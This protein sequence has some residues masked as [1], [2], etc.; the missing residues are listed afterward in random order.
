MRQQPL[1]P[2]VPSTYGYAYRSW[3]RHFATRVA[4][5]KIGLPNGL[6]SVARG[7]RPRPW[8]PAARA[9]SYI[10]HR[11]G[12][13][14]CARTHAMNKPRAEL[15]GL[16]AGTRLLR[17]LFCLLPSRSHGDA[18][19]RLAVKRAD[20][21]PRRQASEHKRTGRPV[22]SSCENS[23]RQ[24]SHVL[25]WLATVT[26]PSIFN[27]C[28]VPVAR[29]AQHLMVARCPEGAATGHGYDVVDALSWRGSAGL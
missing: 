18:F 25:L 7:G 22:L 9:A 26:K 20:A 2:S 21:L 4:N 16:Q 29:P 19:S 14:L 24:N 23:R 17:L 11:Y 15:H 3:I 28:L 13:S 1:R 5:S 6:R 10:A 8:G 27:G 12:S